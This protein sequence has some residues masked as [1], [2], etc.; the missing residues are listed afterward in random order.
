[1]LIY[2]YTFYLLPTVPWPKPSR[3][4]KIKYAKMDKTEASQLSF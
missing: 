4:I 3:K 2:T 1:M